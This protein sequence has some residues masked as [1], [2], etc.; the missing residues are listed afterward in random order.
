MRYKFLYYVVFISF[1]ILNIVVSWVEIVKIPASKMSA[2]KQSPVPPP[3]PL[4][5]C[6]GPRILQNLRDVVFQIVEL[7]L[8]ILSFLLWPPRRDTTLTRP[9]TTVPCN[10]LTQCSCCPCNKWPWSSCCPCTSCSN[11]HVLPVTS[12]PKTRVVRPQ[13]DPNFMS[14]AHNWA[15]DYVVRTQVAPA[16]LGSKKPLKDLLIFN[17]YMFLNWIKIALDTT[18]CCNIP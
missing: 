3:P 16:L 2:I 1:L 7:P 9:C 6:E 13:V 17:T 12:D 8:Y 10:N 14:S 4:S 15:V 18:K 5:F 11:V